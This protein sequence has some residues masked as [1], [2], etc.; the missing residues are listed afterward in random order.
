MTGVTIDLP[1]VICNSFITMHHSKDASLSLIHPCAI[2][3]IL[4]HLN[5]NFSA[6]ILLVPRSVKSINRHSAT[7]IAA[8][9]QKQK[10]KQKKCGREAD[11]NEEDDAAG[12]SSVADE[13]DK[14]KSIVSYLDR[15]SSQLNAQQILLGKL[16]T[17][18][19]CLEQR[20][21]GSSS[22]AAGTASA[23]SIDTVV[24]GDHY[25]KNDDIDD[26]NEEDE[27]EDEDDE[28]GNPK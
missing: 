24:E 13:R 27:D 4:T 19:C 10:Q 16:S 14:L 26:D 12:P 5:M 18:M 3:R 1:L 2:T 20:A 9:M 22:G 21:I 7:Q 23:S 11:N 25:D 17:R 6:A 8:Q 15:I 28:H